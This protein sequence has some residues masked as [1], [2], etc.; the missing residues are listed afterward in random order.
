MSHILFFA[1]FVI[2]KI[3]RFSRIFTMIILILAGVNPLVA[4]NQRDTQNG[5][6]LY[7]AVRI[8]NGLPSEI[9]KVSAKSF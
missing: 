4:Y 3:R 2:Q 5:D 1:W 9:T 7:E 8:K 6:F